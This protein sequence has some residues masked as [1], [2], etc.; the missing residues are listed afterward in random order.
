[1]SKSTIIEDE[2]F[3][4][5]SSNLRTQFSFNSILMQ[6]EKISSNDFI[7]SDFF[8]SKFTMKSFKNTEMKNNIGTGIQGIQSIS[9]ADALLPDSSNPD[10]RKKINKN[11]IITNVFSI[12]ALFLIILII[13]IIILLKRHRKTD[14]KIIDE[15]ITYYSTITQN[16]EIEALPEETFYNDDEDINFWLT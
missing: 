14:N 11:I 4:T 5:K 3:F 7:S 12:L 13:I 10:Q 15:N 8:D 9:S 1:M 16:K 2:F 6:S